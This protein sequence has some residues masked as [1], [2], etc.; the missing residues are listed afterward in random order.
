MLIVAGLIDRSPK[1]AN[2]K[3]AGLTSREPLKNS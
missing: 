2:S 1:L 3:T